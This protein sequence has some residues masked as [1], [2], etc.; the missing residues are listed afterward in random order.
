MY[1]SYQGQGGEYPVY[2]CAS[3]KA[4]C[5]APTCQEVRAEAVDAT[6]EAAFLAAL[7]P[8]RLAL[9]LAAFDEL[10]QEDQALQH[11]WQLRLER[12]RY[13]AQRAERQYQVV[14]PENRLVARTLEHHWELALRALEQVEHAYAAWQ[15]REQA[16]VTAADRERIVA[17]GENLP[18]L[19]HASTTTGADR[20][21]LLRLIIREVVLD[22]R[23]IRGKVWIQITWQTGACT[24]EW[25]QRRVLAYTEHAQAEQLEQR[26]RE[27]HAA[28]QVDT[29]IAEALN[30][31]GF[32]TSKG[33]AFN[34]RAVWYL[35]RQWGLPPV[36]TLS[37]VTPVGTERIVTAE[38]AAQLIGVY[39]TTI[40]KWLRSGR[41]AGV[42]VRAG[43]PWK[44][45]V[46]P[47][48]IQDLRAYA[49]GARRVR[50][51]RR[52]NKEAS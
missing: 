45:I 26:V 9:A 35:R 17:L 25:I 40:Y 28:G 11:Q 5:G 21:R 18:A 52:F 33:G 4:E 24:E 13:E 6:V 49:A 7:A 2:R 16:G 37:R 42:Q 27:L 19:W 38:E 23:R 48:T 3:A 14:D 51:A 39:T 34:G 29:A 20:K 47:E 15:Q 44:V 1:L 8:D 46:S 30:S 41:L 32:Q 50:H 43:L 22:K 36:A 12:A 31:E 10:R